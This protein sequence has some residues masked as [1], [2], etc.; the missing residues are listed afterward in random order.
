LHRDGSLAR[1]RLDL[2]VFRG[3][4]C[5]DRYRRRDSSRPDHTYLIV[6]LRSE[7][8]ARAHNHS[9]RDRS[10]LRRF[11]PIDSSCER[12]VH[13][14]VG[15]APAYVARRGDRWRFHVILRGRDPVALP[16]PV[17]C[18]PRSIDGDPETLL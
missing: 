6:E 7:G 3:A 16:D 13:M 14:M 11:A 17:P 9:S 12:A 2:T 15:P 10:T 1:S 4:G 18:V 5:Q 8:Q